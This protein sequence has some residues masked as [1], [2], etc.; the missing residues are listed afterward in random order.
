MSSLELPLEPAVVQNA[1][2]FVR[3]GLHRWTAYKML[4]DDDNENDGDG[5]LYYDL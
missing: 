1:G 3:F 2:I 5:D 4:G